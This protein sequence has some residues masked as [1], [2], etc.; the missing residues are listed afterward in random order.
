MPH[1]A[2]ELLLHTECVCPFL[3][4]QGSTPLLFRPL[5]PESGDGMHVATYFLLCYTAAL[6]SDPGLVFIKGFILVSYV[7]FCPFLLHVKLLPPLFVLPGSPGIVSDLSPYTY[8]VTLLSR[9]WLTIPYSTFFPTRVAV[10]NFNLFLKFFN[11]CLYSIIFC[12]SF[13]CIV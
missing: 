9:D 4:V 12:L 2:E 5:A 8:S 13:R 11:Y 6:M 3:S 10:S 7:F 1:L